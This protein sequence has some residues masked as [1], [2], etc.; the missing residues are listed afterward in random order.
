MVLQVGNHKDCVF[1]F[2]I[3]VLT[4][5]VKRKDMSICLFSERVGF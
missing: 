2:I 5:V 4:G 3:V 1:N